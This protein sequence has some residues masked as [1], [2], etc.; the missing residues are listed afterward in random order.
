MRKV[1]GCTKCVK[2][3]L[4]FFNFIFWLAGSMV[5]AVGLWL[6]LDPSSVSLFQEEGAP[7]TFFY[8]TYI[9]IGIGAT[10]MIVGFFG[11][12]GAVKESQCLLALFFSSLLIILGAE[13]AAGV[14][15][16]LKKEE[17]IQEV[18]DFY[19]KNG[20][21]TLTMCCKGSEGI[22]DTSLCSDGNN[23]DCLEDI[24][25]FFNEKLFIITCTGVGI[26]AILIIGIILSMVLCRGIQ[27]NR[28]VI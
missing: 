9:I 24:Q 28:E 27:S 1:Q 6:R 5:F 25:L 14:F 15:G 2:Y 12:C 20:N 23:K 17:I 21:T 18:K 3:L 8:V 19:K 4:F 7:A 22:P 13:V 16:F 11:C 10:M 26:A